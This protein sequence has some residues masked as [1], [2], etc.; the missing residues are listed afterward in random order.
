MRI[1]TEEEAVEI[2][3]GAISFKSAA[4]IGAIAVICP[5]AGAAAAVGYLV[6]SDRGGCD[7]DG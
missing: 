4:I 1:I 3:G 6:E 5:I 7:Q 2:P